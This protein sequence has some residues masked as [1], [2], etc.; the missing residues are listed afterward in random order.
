MFNSQQKKTLHEIAHH[1]IEQGLA[2][3]YPLKVELTDYDELLQEKR[4]T[5]VTLK[6]EG[7]LRGCIGIL[8]PIRPLVEDI[9]HNAYAA[10][11]NDHR[12]K[13][14]THDELTRLSIHISVLDIP[15]EIFFE[16]EQDLI[17]QLQPG[18]DGLILE[19]GNL[20]ATFLP[21][22][23]ESIN[24]AKEFIGHLKQKA[25]LPNN[26]WSDTIKARRYSVESF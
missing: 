9:S 12:F 5:F 4:A 19:E 11:F 8:V 15:T 16:S 26:Y 21:S 10:A 17:E 23:W 13:P 25:G 3:G 1:S 18:I 24:D 14:L 2:N 22:V 20:R 6:K 7:D